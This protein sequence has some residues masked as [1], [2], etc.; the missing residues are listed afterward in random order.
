MDHKHPAYLSWRQD[1][2]VLIDAPQ[3]S[4]DNLVY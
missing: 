2:P 3:V 1:R 4:F